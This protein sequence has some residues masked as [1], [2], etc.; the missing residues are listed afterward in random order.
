MSFAQRWTSKTSNSDLGYR[1]N[2]DINDKKPISAINVNSVNIS[3]KSEIVKNTWGEHAPLVQWFLG[4]RDTLPTQSFC[5]WRDGKCSLHW[6]HPMA[7]YRQIT[8]GIYAGPGFE[9][10]DEL[11]SILGQLKSKF[12]GM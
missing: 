1:E 3:E 7:I 5:L 11:I 2:I 12:G 9:Y 6:I 8:D 4:N 10:A